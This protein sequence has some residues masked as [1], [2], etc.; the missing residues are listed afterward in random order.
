MPRSLSADA[1]FDGESC[2]PA[3]PRQQFVLAKVRRSL[4]AVQLRSRR[5]STSQ[6]GCSARCSSSRATG[7]AVLTVYE[8]RSTR[9]GP[10]ALWQNYREMRLFALRGANSVEANQAERDPRGHRPS[11]ARELMDR[12][13]LAR[14][15]RWSAAIFTLTEDLDAEFP[16]VAARRALG[17]DRVPLL[18]TR[19]IPVP[20]SL[21][22][23]HQGAGALLRRARGPRAPPRLP[24]GGPRASPRSRL[25]TM[26]SMTIE[27]GATHPAGSRRIHWPPVMTWAATWRCWPPMSRASGLSPEPSWRAAADSALASCRIAIPIPSYSALRGALSER[28]GM[29][30]GSASRWAMGPA[31]SC[32]QPARRCSSPKPRSCYAWPAFSVYPH[33]AAASGRTGDRRSRLTTRI[34]T[35]SPA[36]AT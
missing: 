17:L 25:G 5:T 34:A 13:S 19:E 4:P 23:R 30:A 14:R 9:T 11:D 22:Q 7:L 29:P 36:M 31:T 27:F 18:C 16:A 20:G 35:I 32:S 12:N 33:L 21:P 10:Q 6:T 26:I 1:L 15:S 2:R 24:G 8:V 28:Y 3:Q